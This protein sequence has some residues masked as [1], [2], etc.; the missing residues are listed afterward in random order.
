[1]L[2]CSTL[3]LTAL[4]T[5]SQAVAADE[6]ADTTSDALTEVVV[7]GSRVVSNGNEQPTPVTVISTEQ[8]LTAAPTTVAAA[9]QELPVFAATTSPSTDAGNSSQ[10]RAVRSMN[11]RALGANR[12][13]VMMDGTRV[14]PI[15]PTAGTDVSYM[16]SMLLQRVDVVTGGASS[17]YGS[18]AVA[19]VVN[20]I[21][22]RNFNGFKIDAH[23]GISSQGDAEED[24]VGLA[25]GMSL[26]GGRGHIE[27]EYEYF[28]SPGIPL[29][30]S[31]S[32]GAAVYTVQNIGTAATGPQYELITNTRIANSSQYGYISGL[33]GQNVGN[34][35]RDMEFTSNGVLTPFQHGTPVINGIEQGGDGYYYDKINLVQAFASNVGFG[36]FD[37]D[38]TDTTHFFATA[39][40]WG[41]SNFNSHFN[42]Q[43]TNIKVSASNAFLA[44]QY[45]QAM[46]NAGITQFTF[47]RVFENI[48][49]TD[50]NTHSRG[51]N[52]NFGIEGKLGDNYKWNVFYAPT[53]NTQMT[54]NDGNPNTGRLVA[55][56]DAVKDSSGNIVC[57]V[58]ITN[59]G[60]YPGC[61]PLNMFGPTSQSQAAVNYIF[62]TTS[63]KTTTIQNEVG[64]TIAG[65]T[66]STWAG[67][68]QSALSGE[69]R[70]LAFST[71]TTAPP[72]PQD[73]TG[74][75]FNCGAST[76][77]WGSN[78][79]AN[80]PPAQQRVYEA[81]LETN[82]PL[83]K[84]VPLAKAVNFIGAV[85]FTDY[86]N[87]GAIATGTSS[88]PN[89]YVTSKFN[90]DTWKLGLDW[91]I[92]DQLKLRGTRSL[93]IRAPTLNEMFAPRLTQVGGTFTDVHTGATNVP[94]LQYT[95]GNPSLV[96]E[97]GRLWS[98]GLVYTPSYVPNFSASVDWY[99]IT[100]KNAIQLVQTQGTDIQ[101]ICENS[102]G[103]S[104]YCALILRPLPFSDHSTANNVTAFILKSFNA[105]LLQSNGVD[106]ELNY[107]AT[108]LPVGKL[109]LRG[110]VSYQ[111]HLYSQLQNAPKFDIAGAIGGTLGSLA[112]P[113]VRATLYVQYIVNDFSVDLRHRYQSSVNW[114]PNPVVI[115]QFITNPR[116][117]SIEYT[118]ITLGYKG[119]EHV[120][121]YFSVQNLFNRQPSAWA[122]TS[123]SNAGLFGGFVDGEDL[124]G[125]YYTFGVRARW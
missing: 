45:Q 21:T 61:Q 40:A 36:R 51:L 88:V 54:R 1:M 44:Q 90:V 107:R 35:L 26:F 38:L 12:T 99:S 108:N 71:S 11:L 4:V 100:I 112:D 7:T 32:F 13:L 56:E 115:S 125:R 79:L 122:N 124:I 37:F 68:I 62:Q 89:T 16:P 43:V 18:D 8:L 102:G 6:A 73:C 109:N 121:P 114:D 66:F 2:A 60:L 27:A 31:R 47:S 58:T 53:S 87:T 72:G 20:F 15:S 80:Q 48:P 33:S 10:N 59:P 77:N 55:A 67:P 81:A 120:E 52:A 78:V 17:V 25:A 111:P 117:A 14:A 5:T 28:N 116:V 74:L 94:A 113:S 3:T 57:N 49:P 65:P 98:A 85:R 105:A 22:D 82:V 106:V 104:P 83:L 39:E 91:D 64:G 50:S 29:K 97:V 103:T 93:D 42:E 96:P 92:N 23:Y 63:F 69:F 123:G 75:R 76:T 46:A 41:S 70:N 110:L 19:G 86:N 118:D 9:L 24:K 95:D 30:P 84:D 34:P 101:T 119:W